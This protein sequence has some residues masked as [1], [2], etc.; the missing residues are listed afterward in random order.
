MCWIATGL[1]WAGHDY[2]EAIKDDKRWQKV[3]EWIRNSGKILTLETI[4]QAVQ[5]LFL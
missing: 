1:T 3:K 2:I 4:K 5:A